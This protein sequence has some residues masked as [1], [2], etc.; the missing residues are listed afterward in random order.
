MQPDQAA[1]VIAA[2]Q[3]AGRKPHAIGAAA[4]QLIQ[5]LKCL[6]RLKAMRQRQNQKLPFGEFQEIVELQ[7][8][9]ALVDLSIVSALAAGEQ[10][11]Q[12]AVSRAVARIDQN[13]RRAV[14]EDEARTDQKLRLVL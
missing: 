7:M 6:C 14:H 5:N 4:L 11:A 2:I 3:Q 1:P 13:I 10:L 8:T 9:F 12:P